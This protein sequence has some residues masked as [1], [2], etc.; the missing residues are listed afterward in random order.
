MKIVHTADWHLGK[1]VNGVHMTSDQRHTLNRF[2]HWMKN[3]Q[4]DVLI[5]AGD[6]YDRSIPPVEAVRLLDDT[7]SRL[8]EIEQLNIIIIA[9]NHD[10]PE[11]LSFGNKIFKNSRLHIICHYDG[12]ISPIVLKD[13][14]GIVKFY[15]IPYI[16]PS[17]VNELSDDKIQTHEEAMRYIV[18]QIELDDTA[19]NICIAHM[20]VTGGYQ[21][22]ES[23]SERPLSIGNVDYVPA[24]VFKAFDYTALG[25]LHKNQK[26]GYSKIQYS[27]SLLKYSFSEARHKKQF[28]VVELDKE[29]R[30]SIERHPVHVR[31]DL[32]VIKGKLHELIS[33]EVYSLENCEDYLKVVLTDEGRL[34]DPMNRLR[35][36]YPNV[37]KLE[38]ENIERSTKKTKTSA[39]ETF[40]S[41]NPLEMFEE[42]Y[43]N[44]A[45][46]ALEKE[47]RVLIKD[48]LN[49]LK[50]KQRR[51]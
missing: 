2:I 29:A 5:I 4:P 15:P 6:V 46:K 35:S 3:I 19:R 10:S 49:E 36:V 23:D 40:Q 14:Y 9:G 42:F 21:L 45:G 26:V 37:L 43:G 11:R 47:N 20:Y 48:I 22:E 16:E 39:S 44:I 7:L 24:D 18:N 12:A 33:E 13:E 38:R 27:G 17:Y 50:R 34:I 28:T 41:L 31:R 32:R 25:H 1:L 51:D 8:L 30:V